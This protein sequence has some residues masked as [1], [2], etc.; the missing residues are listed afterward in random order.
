MGEARRRGT[1]E[2][3][4]AEGE[5]RRKAEAEARSVVVRRRGKSSL[6][7]VMAAAIAHSLMVTPQAQQEKEEG[8]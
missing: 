5:A 4:K 3:R 8:R 1:Y 7:A 2:Q 6:K